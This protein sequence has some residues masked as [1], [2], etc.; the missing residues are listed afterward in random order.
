MQVLLVGSKYLPEY[1]GAAYRIHKTYQRLRHENPGIEVEAICGSIEFDEEGPYRHESIAIKRVTTSC[2]RWRDWRPVFFAKFGYLVHSYLEA[3]KTYRVLRKRSFDVLHVF[4]TSGVAAA[5]ILWAECKKVP[6]VLELVTTGASPAQSLPGLSRWLKLSPGG[7]CLI[8][9]ISR[10]LAVR[11]CDLGFARQTWLR[12]NP[13]D[14]SRFFP[15]FAACHELRSRLTSYGPGDVVALMVAKFMPQKNQ[16]FLLE[17]LA[18]L[19]ENYKLILAGPVVSGGS[20]YDRDKEYLAGI[21]E[22][23]E[24]LGLGGRV[25]IKEEFVDMAQYLRLAD[26]YLLPNTREGLGTPLLESLACGIPVV[27]NRDE[28]AFKQWVRHGID[29]FLVELDAP[30]WASAIQK[31]VLLEGEQMRDASD[32]I[33]SS[34]GSRSIDKEFARMLAKVAESA[35]GGFAVTRGHDEEEGNCLNA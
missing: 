30:A 14:E 18:Q 19:P 32:R 12:P 20:L 23:V 10:E 33:L 13:V 28:D 9:A 34:C 35:E 16:R 7:P 15:D 21:R 27:A 4:G 25:T 2:R 26:V 11:S 1:T 3:W 17:V 5:A 6:M 22:D 29:G 8:V 31:A 24:V